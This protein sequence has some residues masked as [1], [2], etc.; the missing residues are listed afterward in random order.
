MARLMCGLNR[1]IQDQVE[2]RHCFDLD[3]M[4][5]MAM[6]VEQHL[7]QQGAGRVTSGGGSSTSWRPNVAKWEDSKPVSKPKCD[8]KP[9]AQKQGLGHNGSQCPNKKLMIINSCGDVESES[10]QDIENYDDMHTLEDPDDEGYGTVI[11]ELLVTRRVLNAEPK[12]EEE[13]QQENIFQ[14]RCFVNGKVG[15]LQKVTKQVAVPFSIEFIVLF[16]MSPNQVLED[17]MKKKKRDEVEKR[18]IK[19]EFHLNTSD[20]A[21]DLPSIVTSLLQ[22]FKELFPHELPQGLQPLRGIEHQIDFV[23]G[24][25]LP[26]R[27]ACRSNPEETKELQ[28]QVSELLDKGFVRVRIGG[29]LMKGRKPVAYFSEKLNGA[30]LN[31]PTYDKEFY[32]LVRVLET[33]Q[34][35]LRPNEIMIHRHHE[36]LKHLKGQQ[37]LNKIHANWVAFLETLPYVI[38]YKQGKENVVADALSRMY[39]LLTTLDANF[40]Y[41]ELVKELY[42]SDS[43]FGEVYKSCMLSSQGKF[44][45]HD[46]YVYKENRLCIP[47]TSIREFLVRESHG[48]G[49]MGHLCVDK[50]YQVLL[51]HFYWPQ[52]KHDVEKV[53]ERCETYDALHVADLFFNE[54]VRLHDMPRKEFPYDSEID[55]TFHRRQREVRRRL[56]EDE[57]QTENPEEEMAANASLSL[58]QLGTPDLNQQP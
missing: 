8:T 49:L 43:E 46:G 53:C 37:K 9:E 33:W 42:A 6:K 23:P 22:E 52:I 5:Q 47:K 7:K 56:E 17:Q 48:G 30:A 27:P 13:S 24:S 35:Y 25:A 11:G 2:L 40:L 21:R 54:I 19:K 51:E 58:R 41:F 14:T 1:E 18:V 50:T 38:K 3:E 15:S 31:Y 12:E 39:A 4:V 44:Y 55:R 45:L 26:N 36:S 32:A 10:E 16:P 29:V 28:K 57:H 20:I 34:H